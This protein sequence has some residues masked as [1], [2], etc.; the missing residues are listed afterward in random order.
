MPATL[1]SVARLKARDRIASIALTAAV[2]LLVGCKSPYI[3]TIITNNTGGTVTLIEVDYPSASFGRDVLA[4]NQSF[5]YRFQIIGEG[6]TKATWTDAA[7]HVHTSNGPSL[8]NGQHG[9]MH[10]TLTPSGAAW[11]SHLSP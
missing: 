3:A 1:K 10:I 4:A 5:S 11:D 7:R 6:A 9:Q 8:H 2:L